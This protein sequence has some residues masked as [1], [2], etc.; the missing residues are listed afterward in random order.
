M[1]TAF[2]ETEGKAVGNATDAV[3]TL[4]ERNHAIY[5]RHVIDGRSFRQ[6]AGE[7]GLSTSTC[8]KACR[9]AEKTL[10]DQ[11]HREI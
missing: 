8:W 9:E 7:Y 10:S 6:L 5:Q 2:V 11:F 1:T 3:I 4:A